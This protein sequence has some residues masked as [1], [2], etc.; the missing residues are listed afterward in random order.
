MAHAM[1]LPFLPFIPGVV[2][3][4]SYLGEAQVL[5]SLS[6]SESARVSPIGPQHRKPMATSS[7]VIA[8]VVQQGRETIRRADI[9]GKIVR[10]SPCHMLGLGQ[11]P[12]NFEASET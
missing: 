8:S 4:V 12:P 7:G 1:P 2:V 10:Q 3:T 6:S 9:R 5:P 11:M